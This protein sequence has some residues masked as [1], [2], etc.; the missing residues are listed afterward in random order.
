MAVSKNAHIA[1]IRALAAL[2]FVLAFAIATVN[3]GFG[4]SLSP[5]AR[6]AWKVAYFYYEYFFRWLTVAA[7]CFLTWRSLRGR[8]AAA[9]REQRFTLVSYSVSSFLLLVVLPLALGYWEIYYALMPFPWTTLPLQL[10][11]TGGYFGSALPAWRGIDSTAVM[12]WAYFLYQGVVLVGTA[13]M[14]RKWQCGMICM[15]NGC[16]AESLGAGL[17][18]FP[19]D[20]AKPGSKRL[21]GGV[22]KALLAARNILF[23][24]NLAFFA[25]WALY[26]AFGFEPLPLRLLMRAEIVKYVALELALLMALWFFAGSRAYCFYCPAGFALALASRAAGQRIETGLTKCIGCGACDAACKMS[27]DVMAR[28]AAGKPVQDLSCVGCG[29]CVDACPTGNLAYRTLLWNRKA[30]RRQSPS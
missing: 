9:T 22:K 14:G 29:L 20:P 16:H 24:V 6:H 4:G 30:G 7:G 23:P 8:K 15:L 5:A 26:A 13:V 18:L 10:A 28:A 11:A 3:Y 19:H 27:V 25:L 1:V 12:L 21:R 17:P 2:L